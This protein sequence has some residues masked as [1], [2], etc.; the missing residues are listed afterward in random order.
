MNKDKAH[1]SRNVAELQNYLKS[2]GC[3]ENKS[4]KLNAYSNSSCIMT[5]TKRVKEDVTNSYQKG[6]NTITGW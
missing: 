2:L 5:Q 1:G 6:N 4:P 3:G